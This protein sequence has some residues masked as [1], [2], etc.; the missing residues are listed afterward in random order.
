MIGGD[1]P[2]LVRNA[3]VLGVGTFI[4]TFMIFSGAGWGI[5]ALL[6]LAAGGGAGWYYYDKKREDIFV[7][8]LIHGRFFECKSIVD[9]ARK[10]AWL[11]VVTSVFRQIMESAKNW[12]GTETLAVEVLNE[13]ESKY[14]VLRG[15]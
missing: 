10:E 5:A 2:D 12:D 6:G 15:L 9:L 1:Q 3:R 7:K 4:L 8:D 13:Q 14:A 11:G